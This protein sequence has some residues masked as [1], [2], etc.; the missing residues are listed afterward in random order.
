MARNKIKDKA[1]ENHIIYGKRT[2]GQKTADTITKWGGSWT[3]IFLFLIFILAWIVLNTYILLNKG[4]DPQPYR[5]LNLVLSCLAALQAP[6]ILMSQYRAAERD[7]AKAE[8]DY[9]VNRKAERE[10]ENVQKDLNEIK[11]LI[12]YRHKVK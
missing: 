7:R 2:F 4:F 1:L 9:F 10:I 8:R 6:I 3:F 11:S 12:K 5:L